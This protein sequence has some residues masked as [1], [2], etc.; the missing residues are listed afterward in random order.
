MPWLQALQGQGWRGSQLAASRSTHFTRLLT[1]RSVGQAP[2][3][4]F[5]LFFS[6]FICFIPVPLLLCDIQAAISTHA[7]NPTIAALW[8]NIFWITQVCFLVAVSDPVA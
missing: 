4:Y 2:G 5:L 7:Y 1:G 3:V 6:Y 8:T